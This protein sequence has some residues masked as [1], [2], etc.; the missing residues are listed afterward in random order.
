M[1]LLSF[2]WLVLILIW[3]RHRLVFSFRNR[4]LPDS[5]IWQL[6]KFPQNIETASGRTLVR[7]H[8][9]I[10][11]LCWGAGGSRDATQA[12]LLG[13]KTQREASL[14]APFNLPIPVYC[15]TA[16]PAFINILQISFCLIYQMFFHQKLYI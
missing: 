8:A 14:A 4:H 5:Q 1:I 10:Y 15:I 12:L 9:N 16:S 13:I 3:S 11:K 2:S 6:S 7:R